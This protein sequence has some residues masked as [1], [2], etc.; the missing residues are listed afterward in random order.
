MDQDNND[1]QQPGVDRTGSDRFK[2]DDSDT[3]EVREADDNIR[4]AQGDDSSEGSR[5]DRSG[6]RPRFDRDR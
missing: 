6:N 1:I 4:Q 2:G 3:Q 5:D